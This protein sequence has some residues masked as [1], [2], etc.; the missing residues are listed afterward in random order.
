MGEVREDLDR[1]GRGP[2][3]EWFDG[4]NPQA[5]AK[6]AIAVTRI[7]QGKFS[8]VRSVGSGVHECKIKFGPGYRVYFGENGESLVILTRRRN[9]KATAKGHQLRYRDVAGL[10]DQKEVR[11]I[12]NG[13]DPRLQ[14][15][16]SSAG[17]P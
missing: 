15:Y 5:A 6:V 1:N 8:N 4:L 11:R 12:S 10:Q 9:E 2:Y 7:G 3:P 16:N 14:R 13:S 17:P